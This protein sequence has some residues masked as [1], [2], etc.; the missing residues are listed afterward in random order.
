MSKLITPDSKTRGKVPLVELKEVIRKPFLQVLE[1]YINIKTGGGL[2][3]TIKMRTGGKNRTVVGNGSQAHLP[4]PIGQVDNQMITMAMRIV[5][6]CTVQVACGM[7][8]IVESTTG[9][10]TIPFMSVKKYRVRI[11]IPSSSSFTF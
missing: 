4:T 10:E 9:M 1:I 8:W 11:P 5:H 6:T 2:G 7:I 3:T